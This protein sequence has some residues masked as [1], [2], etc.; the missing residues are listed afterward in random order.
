M[1]EVLVFSSA[2]TCPIAREGFI[3]F[4]HCESFKSYMTNS[5]TF[6]MTVM[7]SSCITDLYLVIY[8]KAFNV[9][10]RFSVRK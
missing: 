6:K 4:I 1:Y 5:V 10:V 9:A 3:A 7:L 2:L 8:C